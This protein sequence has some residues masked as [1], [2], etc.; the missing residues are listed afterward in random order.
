MINYF[1]RIY[2]FR[3]WDDEEK[4]FYYSYFNCHKNDRK[5]YI[6]HGDSMTGEYLSLTYFLLT[7]TKK[8]QI[9]QDT[10]RT[11]KNCVS[12]FEGDLIYSEEMVAPID[13][14]AGKLRL[15]LVYYDKGSYKLKN[16]VHNVTLDNF[17]KNFSM[18]VRGNIFEN[19]NLF[20]EN[21]YV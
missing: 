8:L 18:E 17:S 3:A 15:F 10:E 2:K 7:K 1:R 6:F 14:K 19:P 13:K 21:N 11:D 9:T 4:K 20:Y 16:D 12:I 5:E